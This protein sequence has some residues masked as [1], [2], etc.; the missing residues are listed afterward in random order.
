MIA[1]FVNIIAISSNIV[2]KHCL[3]YVDVIVYQIIILKQN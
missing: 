1:V 2:D 3:G